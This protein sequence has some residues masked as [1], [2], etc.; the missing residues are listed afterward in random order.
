MPESKDLCKQMRALQ[1]AYP[2]YSYDEYRSKVYKCMAIQ[3]V[4]TGKWI[5]AA[6]LKYFKWRN[7]DLEDYLISKIRGFAVDPENFLSKFRIQPNAPLLKML[8]EKNRVY[9]KRAHEKKVA[10][11]KKMTAA[12]TD[13]GF[14]V[15]GSAV[16]KTRSYWLYPFP[17]QNK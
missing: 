9:D 10:N 7:L 3:R 14:F 6:S 2:I 1:D 5:V 12:L 16:A 15:P 13:A 11:F 17:I 4:I 8:F